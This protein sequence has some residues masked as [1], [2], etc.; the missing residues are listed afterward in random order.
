M[1]FEWKGN[2]IIGQSNWWQEGF[3]NSFTQR[4][5]LPPLKYVKDF[6][7]TKYIIDMIV[8]DVNKTYAN[9][10]IKWW[11]DDPISMLSTPLLSCNYRNENG[12]FIIV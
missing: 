9:F 12:T 3:M 5:I 8:V 1:Y 4:I 11:N 2:N 6:E 7:Q 10:T